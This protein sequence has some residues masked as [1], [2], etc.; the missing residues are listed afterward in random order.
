MSE[1]AAI[2]SPIQ[3]GE[4]ISQYIQQYERPEFAPFFAY[5]LLIFIY[6]MINLILGPGSIGER[7]LTFIA[8][9]VVSV[10]SVLIFFLSQTGRTGYAW[11]TVIILAI[12]LVFVTIFTI[13]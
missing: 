8:T 4:T 5:V 9:V 6:L 3:Q 2:P 12:F 10:L 13:W 11:M 7:I 1:S